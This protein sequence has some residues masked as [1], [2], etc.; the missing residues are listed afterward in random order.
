M[1]CGNKVALI[2]IIANFLSF[3]WNLIYGAEF[4][5]GINASAIIVIALSIE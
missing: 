1:K 5:A 2:L 4:V 3:I